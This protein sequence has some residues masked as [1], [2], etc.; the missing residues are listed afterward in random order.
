MGQRD[1]LLAKV[2]S[3]TADANIS[4]EPLRSLLR[5]L[6]FEERLR[7]SHHIFSKEGVDEILNLQPKQGKVK[8][9]QVKQVRDV[10]VKY[11]MGN[12]DAD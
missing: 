5:G 6:G 12:R 10:I 7:G 8:T 1:K 4:F 11:K 2:L 9:Y 3:G